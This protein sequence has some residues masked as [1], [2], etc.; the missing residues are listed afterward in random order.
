MSAAGGPWYRA[1]G[2]TYLRYANVCADLLRSV[3]KEPHKTKA[4]TRG[5]ISYRFSP[6]VDGK[7][8]KQSALMLMY[9]RHLQSID[10]D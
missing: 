5:V 1:A 3:L 10:P 2:W 4:A 9:A 7:A 6:Y 8:G